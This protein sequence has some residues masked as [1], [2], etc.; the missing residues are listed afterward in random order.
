MNISML[1]YEDLELLKRKIAERQ[2]YLRNLAENFMYN[3]FRD[4]YIYVLIYRNGDKGYEQTGQKA[5]KKYSESSDIIR[6]DRKTKDLRPKW[7]TLLE[8]GNCNA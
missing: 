8:K 7:E 5:Y 2:Q 4:D 1:N 3:E 6:L